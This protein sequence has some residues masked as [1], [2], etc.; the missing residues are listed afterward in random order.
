[1]LKDPGALI[2]IDRALESLKKEISE[3]K[4]RIN[5]LE[6]TKHTNYIAVKD[7]SVKH[8][9]YYIIEPSKLNRDYFE[10]NNAMKELKEYISETDVSP[11]ELM[12]IINEVQ[13]ILNERLHIT[14]DIM[15]RGPSMF[16]LKI[17]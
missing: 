7:N 17:K 3:M 6:K 12:E 1:M 9:A 8:T 13:E 14:C 2:A 16:E 11:T 5:E 15:L 10:G 4:K